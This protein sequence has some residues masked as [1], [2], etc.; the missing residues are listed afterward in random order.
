MSVKKG[1]Q[2]ILRELLLKPPCFFTFIARD[3]AASVSAC[4]K[5]SVNMRSGLAVRGYKLDH[6]PADHIAA[7]RINIANAF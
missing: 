6:M 2:P 1:R 5:S 3:C 7:Y 4:L